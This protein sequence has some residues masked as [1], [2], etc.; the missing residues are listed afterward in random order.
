[1]TTKILSAYN[2]AGITACNNENDAFDLAV[3]IACDRGSR[4][5][6]ET[7]VGA[8]FFVSSNGDIDRI[9]NDDD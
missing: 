8:R 3:R 2:F 6:V 5:V 7:C 9:G 1:M 4:V